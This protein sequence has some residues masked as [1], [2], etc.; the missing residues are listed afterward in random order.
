MKALLRKF[1]G[2]LPSLFCFLLPLQKNLAR[3]SGVRSFTAQNDRSALA[4]TAFVGWSAT[5]RVELPI[6]AALSAIC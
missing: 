3:R 4:L 2:I 1:S 6:A 5:P